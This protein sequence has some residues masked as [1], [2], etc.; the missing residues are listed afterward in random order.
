MNLK[1]LFLI[2]GY[3]ILKADFC[4]QNSSLG[5]IDQHVALLREGINSFEK[6]E[7]ITSGFGVQFVYLKDGDVQIITVTAKGKVE[8]QV[9]WFYKKGVLLYTET[10]WSDSASLKPLFKEKTYH[11]NGTMIAWL[12]NDNSFVDSSSP[13]F[14]KLEKEINAYATKIRNDALE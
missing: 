7:K 9:E 1:T 4:A 8:K 14:K 12:D 6:I 3:F 10:N 13:K 5:D 11:T 2:I